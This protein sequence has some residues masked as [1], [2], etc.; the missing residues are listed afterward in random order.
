MEGQSFAPNAMSQITVRNSVH[1]YLK[2]VKRCGKDRKN[3]EHK[4]CEI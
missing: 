4:D 3:G 2:V 1:F